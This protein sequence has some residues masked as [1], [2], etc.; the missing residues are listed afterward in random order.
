MVFLDYFEP[1]LCSWSAIYL[2]IFF[3]TIYLFYLDDEDLES[4]RADLGVDVARNLRLNC[5]YGSGMNDNN[6]CL[7]MRDKI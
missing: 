4:N 5:W 1:Q 7:C 6:F 3:I 2:S